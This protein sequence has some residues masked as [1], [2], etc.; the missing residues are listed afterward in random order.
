M[1][2]LILLLIA[3]ALVSINAA[4]VIAII[5]MCFQREN[6]VETEAEVVSDQQRKEMEYQELLMQGLDNIMKYDGSPVRKERDAR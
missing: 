4:M 6:T 5:R 1:T 3:L 2:E